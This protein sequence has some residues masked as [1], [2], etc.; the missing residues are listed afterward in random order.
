MAGSER[1]DI[2]GE[3]RLRV[4]VGRSVFLATEGS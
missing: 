1:N 4:P 3:F 2:R